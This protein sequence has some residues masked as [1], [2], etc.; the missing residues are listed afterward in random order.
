MAKEL[1][2]EPPAAPLGPP[3]SG[4]S[5]F[6]RNDRL[7]TGG[8]WTGKSWTGMSLAGQFLLGGAAVLL[9]GMLIIGLWVTDRIE[10]G[11]IENSAVATA[12]YVDSIIA[13]L[14]PSFDATTGLGDGARRALDETLSQ[15]ALGQRLV[16]FKI[17]LADGSVIYSSDAA[18]VGQRF[19][20]T[21]NLLQA[22]AGKVAAEF[23]ELSDEENATERGGGEPLLEIYSPIREAWSGRIVAVAEFY[24]IAG[25]L[26][27][28]LNAARSESWIVVAAVTL[29]MLGLLSG[30]VLRGNT[31]IKQ[32]RRSLETQVGDLSRLLAVNEQ[33]RQHLQSASARG[34][35]LNERYLR[36]ISAD[37]HDGPVQLMALASL[38]LGGNSI[39]TEPAELEGIRSVLD[40][41][42]REIRDVCN[43]LALPE[44]E[45]LTLT[46]LLGAAT[47]AHEH[48]TGHA[49]RLAAPDGDL[50]L[51]QT[52]K[53]AIYRFV[54]EGLNNAS[55]H[56]GGK[57]LSV[58]ASV[59]EDGL[60]VTVG[61]AGPGF[62][63]AA[64]RG[65]G[66]GLAGLR[67]R[68]ES[69]GGR[70]GIE[71][72]ATGTVLT[73]RLPANRMPL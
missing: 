1:I 5:R 16:V 45:T 50:A 43:G 30:I 56:G 36:R 55:R 21:P 63:I 8:S 15:G 58:T 51:S 69:L 11:V 27:G 66:L 26:Q 38:R 19:V 48:R 65:A 17:W 62:D 35:A 31:V 12:L 47:R 4:R 9:G 24:E 67:D 33:L 68:I 25:E 73:M 52:E 49:V 18:L 14:L 37:L 57:A 59:D 7:R 40:D 23:D 71:S 54:Q 20:P 44:V 60:R 53:I 13:P 70:F 61:D 64:S 2:T 42:M 3:A 29:G 28:S 39:A 46:A 41:A 22:F 6:F 10:T 72:A 32:Q 34:A